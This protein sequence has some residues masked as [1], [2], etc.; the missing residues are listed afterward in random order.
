M[1]TRTLLAVMALVV[2][3]V[4]TSAAAQD[5]VRVEVRRA[6][7]K[8]AEGLTEA[9][10]VGSEQK[11]YLHAKPELTNDDIAGAA[12]VVDN[13]GRPA[14]EIVFTEQGEQ[15][16]A[17]LSAD[18]LQRPLAVLF[19]GKVYCAPILRQKL[20]KKAVITGAFTKTEAERIA[21][22]LHGKAAG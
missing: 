21:N 20:G 17:K 1:T 9:K 10:V 2:L 22:S 6:E 11:I 16:I 18:H 13:N 15:K 5:K 19:D 4:T 14:V 7:T 12:V 3:G 8:A